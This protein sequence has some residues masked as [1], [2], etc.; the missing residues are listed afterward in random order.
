MFEHFW[1]T[2]KKMHHEL[3]DYI[4]WSQ[5]WTIAYVIYAVS[6]VI[7]WIVLGRLIKYFRKNR[8]I[9]IILFILIGIITYCDFPIYLTAV[10][11]QNRTQFDFWITILIPTLSFYVLIAASVKMII[12]ALSLGLHARAI[13]GLVTPLILY[14]AIQLTV[15][16]AYGSSAGLFLI[17]VNSLC[18]FVKMLLIP[19]RGSGKKSKNA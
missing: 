15:S 12:D 11:N 1:R 4:D 6:S 17:G 7:A 19:P 14:L 2:F 16:M 9:R 3:S 8:N 18:S 13:H 5:K 10:K